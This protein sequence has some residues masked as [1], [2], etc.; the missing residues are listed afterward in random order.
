[1]SSR[2]CNLENLMALQD[3]IVWAFQTYGF[4]SGAMSTNRPCNL[5]NLM[6]LQ[7]TIVWA[8]T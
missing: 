1:M 3:T 4:P 5:E 2:P 7:D 8:W 6:A